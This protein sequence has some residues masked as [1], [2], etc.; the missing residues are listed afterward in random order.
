M[1]LPAPAVYYILVQQPEDAIPGGYVLKLGVGGPATPGALV[2]PTIDT[3]GSEDCPV[4]TPSASI[5]PAL[6]FTVLSLAAG[7]LFA[8]RRRLI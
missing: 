2:T 3:D 6:G 5:C 8:L 4:V 1:P 7:A